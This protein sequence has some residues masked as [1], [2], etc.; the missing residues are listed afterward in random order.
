MIGFPLGANVDGGQ[1]LRGQVA[2]VDGADEIDMAIN[3]GWLKDGLDDAC[4]KRS[5]R[6]R[7]RS[8][9]E[10]PWLSLKPRCHRRGRRSACKFSVAGGAD[11]V[12]TSTGFGTGGATVEDVQLMLDTVDARPRSKASG[13]VRDARPRRNTSKW[14]SCAGLGTSNGIKSPLARQF[15][16]VTERPPLLCRRSTAS[17]SSFDSAGVGFLPDAGEYGD[18]GGDPRREHAGHIGDAGRP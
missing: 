13:S 9:R 15:T 7:R 16:E 3:V 2:V 8:V 1:G 18:S 11:F 17:S 6:S 12:K 5:A 4:A 14:E 10:C